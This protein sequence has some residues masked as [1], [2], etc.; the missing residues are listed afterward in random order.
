MILDSKRSFL[1]G[2]TSCPGLI[3]FRDFLLLLQTDKKVIAQ[4]LQK[5][6]RLQSSHSF[7]ACL[8]QMLLAKTFWTNLL[9]K[10]GN[11]HSVE[12]P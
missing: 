11:N 4:L 6:I 5:I 1:S 2:G 9:H 10:I 3:T 12:T 7:R 8:L